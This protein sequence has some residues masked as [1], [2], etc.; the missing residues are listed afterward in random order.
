M[1][2][3][4]STNEKRRLRNSLLPNKPHIVQN[5]NSKVFCGLY[6]KDGKFF[7]TA[8]QGKFVVYLSC[9]ILCEK[10]HIYK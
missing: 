1:P 10:F 3:S 8:T 4:F 7:I 5:Y 2:D 9:I 6:S